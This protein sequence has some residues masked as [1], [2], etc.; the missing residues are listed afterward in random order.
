MKVVISYPPLAGKGSPMLT[1]NRQFQWYHVP[2]FIY[3]V[4]AAMA[5]TILEQEGF[6]VVWNDCIAQKLGEEQFYSFMGNEKPGLIA[7]ETKTPIIRQHWKIIERLK[8]NYPE[9]RVALF[10]DH[11]TALPSESMQ[12]SKVDFV[13]TGGNYDLSLLAVA[14]HLRDGSNLPP[15]VWHR[16]NGEIGNTGPF[17]LDA[18][19]NKLPFINR[20]L[21]QAHLYG[22]KWK[23]R[24]RFFYTMVGRDCQ[25]GKCAFCSWTT[26]Y[27]RFHARSPESL[28]DE[29]GMLIERHGAQEIFDDTGTFPAGN[30]LRKFCK[31]MID[32]GYNKKILFSCNM[33]YAL[34][35]P[36]HIK[37]MKHAGFRKVKMG[38]ESANQKTLDLIDKGIKVQDI[39]DGSKMIS[40]GGIDIQ[41][42]VMVGYPWETREDAQRT[43]D[44]AKE[45]MARGHAEMLQSTV[46]VPYPGT[47]LHKM[48]LENNWFRIDPND[49]ELYDMSQPTLKTPDMA[50]ADILQMC[51]GVYQSFLTPRYILRHISKIRSIRD[52]DYVLRGSKAV[53]GHLLDFARTKS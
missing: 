40:E 20:T 24:K 29:I 28:L 18:D 9:M 41:L 17:N 36:E 19:L 31:G 5:A 14:K 33:R 1:Q 23:K 22:E 47:P 7:I 37:L 25:W 44:L 52:L 13:I 27:P 8:Q 12:H 2:S 11:V 3:P 26:L 46:V 32:R 53:V 38:L 21:T 43:V 51:R 6:E 39:I 16:K 45:L 34:L 42:T 49:Y 4:V 15:G 48:A 35:K 50:P 30:W 10:G